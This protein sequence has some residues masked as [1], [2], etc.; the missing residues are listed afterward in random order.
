MNAGTRGQIENVTH[1]QPKEGNVLRR[2]QHTSMFQFLM[3]LDFSD[4]E[5][6][7]DK[8]YFVI[9]GISLLVT[10]PKI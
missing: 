9:L 1:L 2:P 6:N 7:S 8:W 5:L 10:T 3:H 4:S